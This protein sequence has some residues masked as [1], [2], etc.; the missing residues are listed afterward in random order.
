VAG[1]GTL[2]GNYDN[3]VNI[4]SAQYTYTF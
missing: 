4:L 1:A 2:L 3:S